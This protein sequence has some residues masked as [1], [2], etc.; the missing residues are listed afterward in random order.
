MR[1]EFCLMEI[2]GVQ[3]DHLPD[4]PVSHRI[5]QWPGKSQGN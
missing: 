3:G 4:K 5:P 2:S 1:G